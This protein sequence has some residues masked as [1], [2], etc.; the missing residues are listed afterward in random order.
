[1]NKVE[2]GNKREK[3][4]MKGKI[5]GKRKNILETKTYFCHKTV[6]S[7]VSADSRR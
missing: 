5:K 7:S 3:T 1:M 2:K 4:E 6:H